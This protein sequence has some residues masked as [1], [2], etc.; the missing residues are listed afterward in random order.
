MDAQINEDNQDK[1]NL[2]FYLGDLT[3]LNVFF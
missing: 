2:K 1:V 3:Y